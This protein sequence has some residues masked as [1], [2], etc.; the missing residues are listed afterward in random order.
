MTLTKL[1]DEQKQEMLDAMERTQK[2]GMFY[3]DIYRTIIK[4]IEAGKI[5]YAGVIE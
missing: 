2:D 3:L 1:T 5:P 4:A